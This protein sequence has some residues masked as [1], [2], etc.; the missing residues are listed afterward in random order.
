MKRLKIKQMFLIA[1]WSRHW[2]FYP[3]PIISIDRTEYYEHY[4]YGFALG[5]LVFV[6]DVDF[7]LKK[8]S[9]D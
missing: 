9:N 8:K 5:W 1:Q 6:L 7:E 4:K 3:L 2:W